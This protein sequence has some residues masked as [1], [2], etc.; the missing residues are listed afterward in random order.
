MKIEASLPED[1]PASMLLNRE[2]LDNPYPFYARLRETAPVWRVPG[3]EIFLVSRYAL[4][5]EA[6]SRVEDFS[7]NMRG[8]VYRRLNGKPARLTHGGLLQVLATADP[9]AH[10]LHKRAVFPELVAKRMAAMAPEIEKVADDCIDRLLQAGSGDFMAIVANPLPITVVNKL[11]GFKDAD[12]G[13]MLQGAFDSSA[14]VGGTSTVFELV[15][16]MLR[17]FVTHRWIA[18]QLRAASTVGDNILA[19]VKR[20]TASGA[21]REAEGRAILH[22]LLAAGGES[23][24]SLLGNA[25]RILADDQALQQTL[26]AQPELIPNF[27]EEVLRLESPFRHHLRSAA[28]DTILGGVPIPAGATILMFWSAGNRDPAAFER[29]DEIDLARPRRHMTFGKGI[30][31]CVGAPLARLE[32]QIV[33]RKLLARTRQI[34]LDPSRPPRRVSSLQVRRYEQLPITVTGS[35]IIAT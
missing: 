6:A 22:I 24:T 26:R 16:C 10:T 9:P 23:T 2:V 18:G 35:S 8:V 30:H 7:S 5:E 1:I 14:V 29:A 11:I 33:L 25:V 13:K 32:G 17:S 15:L 12:I 3:T 34:V 28:R 21:L 4:L 27:M 31:M 20:S 19:S